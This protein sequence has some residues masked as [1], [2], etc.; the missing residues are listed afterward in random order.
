MCGGIFLVAYNQFF[1]IKC[2][3]CPDLWNA[4]FQM[5]W[6]PLS[7]SHE[8]SWHCQ[9]KKKCVVRIGTMVGAADTAGLPSARHKADLSSHTE[10]TLL[11]PTGQA[12]FLHTQ[13]KDSISVNTRRPTFCHTEKT[14]LLHAQSWPPFYIY[15]PTQPPSLYIGSG[16]NDFQSFLEYAGSS[17]WLLPGYWIFFFSCRI[18][19]GRHSLTK[20]APGEYLVSLEAQPHATGTSPSRSCSGCRHAQLQKLEQLCGKHLC[21]LFQSQF[22]ILEVIQMIKTKINVSL[23]FKCQLLRIRG[24][25][26][27]PAPRGACL[28]FQTQGTCAHTSWDS[29]ADSHAVDKKVKRLPALP[30]SSWTLEPSKILDK[31][32]S[33]GLTGISLTFPG[34]N[35]LK[36]RAKAVRK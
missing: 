20:A 24:Q 22:L 31:K 14:S 9:K 8:V 13:G 33:C 17:V 18:V 5:Q 34:S 4:I 25:S 21:L 11:Q 36:A 27:S 12:A 28:G 1:S 6:G 29:L 10:Q 23:L 19:L 15:R 7:M 16:M 32:I 2:I 30:P 3:Q 35:L 26:I